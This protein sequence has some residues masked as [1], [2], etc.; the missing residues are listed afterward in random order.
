MRQRFEPAAGVTISTLAYDYPPRWH[1]P[2][3]EHACDQLVYAKSGVMEV[4]VTQ[5]RWLI[6]PQFAIWIPAHVRHSIRMPN[7]VAMRT[8]Y[9]RS[10]LARPRECQ[11]LHVSPLL[12]ELIVEAVRIGDLKARRRENAALSA[13]LVALINKASPIPTMLAMPADPRA[14]RLAESVIS[15]PRQAA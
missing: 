10:R 11:V 15:N 2:E 1:V 5:S 14:R 8:L 7:A 3:H 6:P 4:N 13:L 9:L 12:R